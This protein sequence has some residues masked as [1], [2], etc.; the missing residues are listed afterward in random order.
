M[1]C[2]YCTGLIVQALV[3]GEIQAGPTLD[4]PVALLKQFEAEHCKLLSRIGA[5][6]VVFEEIQEADLPNNFDR[7]QMVRE[8]KA[9][10]QDRWYRR[11]KQYYSGGSST[12]TRIETDYLIVNSQYVMYYLQGNPAAYMWEHYSLDSVQKQAAV[13]RDLFA[14]R[15][16]MKHGFGDGYFSL[17][18]LLAAHTNAN[19]EFRITLT[20]DRLYQVDVL[21]AGNKKAP[22]CT[23]TIDGNKGF[24]ITDVVAYEQASGHNAPVGRVKISLEQIEPGI[25]FPHQWD[26]YTYGAP[27]VTGS[28]QVIRHFHSAL[29]SLKIKQNF[30]SNQFTWLSLPMPATTFVHRTDHAGVATVLRIQGGEL[31]STSVDREEK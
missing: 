27:D 2:L 15:D 28:P 21:D 9:R 22:G 7:V 30:E 14:V 4:Q 16:V 12:P 29:T 31:L 17:S 23:Y 18:E 26:H 6:A 11:T 13:H 5:Y 20:N 25:W 8:Q 24:L 19:S 3:G 1:T 10:F